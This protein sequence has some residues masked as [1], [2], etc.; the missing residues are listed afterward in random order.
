MEGLLVIRMCTD[1]IKCK[2]GGQEDSYFLERQ[3]SGIFNPLE[4]HPNPLRSRYWISTRRPR[5]L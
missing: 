4:E 3:F 2:L 5:H 1:K